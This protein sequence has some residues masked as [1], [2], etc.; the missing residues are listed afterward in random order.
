GTRDWLDVYWAYPIARAQVA[1]QLPSGRPNL[2][3]N[4]QERLARSMPDLPTLP[5]RSQDILRFLHVRRAH[6]PSWSPEAAA[7]AYVADTSGLDQAW[8]I[9]A[10]G[11]EPRQ[12]TAFGER[13]GVVKWS[14]DGTQLL[15]SVD[16]GGNEHD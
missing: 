16:A 1:R 10:A 15:V 2:N 3:R 8:V 12:L 5:E 9:P 4:T 13:V 11:G 6:G 7:I 14:P